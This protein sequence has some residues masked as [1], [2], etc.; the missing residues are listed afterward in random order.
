VHAGCKPAC[1]ERESRTRT[2]RPASLRRL[3][4]GPD[5]RSHPRNARARPLAD[6]R[7]ARSPASH[8]PRRSAS[9]RD[10]CLPAVRH[11]PRRP[12]RSLA[13]SSFGSCPPPLVGSIAGDELSRGLAVTRVDLCAR[14]RGDWQLEVLTAVFSTLPPAADSSRQTGRIQIIGP[15]DQLYG[16]RPRATRIVTSS[17]SDSGYTTRVLT[18]AVGP[19]HA[20]IRPRRHRLLHTDRP[21]AADHRISVPIGGALAVPLSWLD[22]QVGES[23]RPGLAGTKCGRGELCVSESCWQ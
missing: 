17:R 1:R 22:E 3:V 21:S 19:E 15:S 6:R 13:L 4:R 8:D 2:N 11:E 10:S 16:F 23:V 12:P 9:I 20:T 5:C 18:P 7:W 14:R